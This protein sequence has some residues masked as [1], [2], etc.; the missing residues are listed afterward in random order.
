MERPGSLA[1]RQFIE[2]RPDF[3]QGKASSILNCS[4]QRKQGKVRRKPLLA[5][6]ASDGTA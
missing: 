2:K 4:P 6:R 3:D 5:L 1:Q